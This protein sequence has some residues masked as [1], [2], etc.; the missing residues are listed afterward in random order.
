[1]PISASN[2]APVSVL[3]CAKNEELN[4]KNCLAG[5]AWADDVVV[6]DSFSDDAT[7]DMARQLGARVVQR[8]F[9]YF[10]THR[11]WALDR[12]DFHH[13]WVLI[14][15]ADERVSP[16]LAREI[17]AA[18]AGVVVTATSNNWPRPC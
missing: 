2:K 11:N 10:S 5:V 16:A 9:D 17:A 8:K 14:L 13:D 18:G 6:L 3:I 1:M 4:L 12:I 15:D 7:V